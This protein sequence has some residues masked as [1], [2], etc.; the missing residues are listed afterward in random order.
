RQ[1]RKN[2]HPTKLQELGAGDVVVFGS[3][4][5]G[6][7]VLDTVF[8]V[9]DSIPYEP[10]TGESKLGTRVPPS[11]LHATMRPLAGVRR[12][13]AHVA[14]TV[15]DPCGPEQC[16]E[17]D[18]TAAC[19]PPCAE[20]NAARFR[21]YWG[22]TPS[23]PI[24]GMFS[25]APAKTMAETIVPFQRPALDMPFISAGLSQNWRA[26]PAEAQPAWRAIAERVLEQG[27]ELGVSFEIVPSKRSF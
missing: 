12:P 14:K 6:S 7:F 27:L 4:M 17:E 22:A 19:G 18:E 8:V 25:F 26:C 16:S 11:F 23:A 24:D 10:A 20:S 1:V 13:S 15:L 5:N 9:A 2:G 3:H 21:L